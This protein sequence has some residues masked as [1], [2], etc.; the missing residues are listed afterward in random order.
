MS[1]KD[2]EQ[3]GKAQYDNPA[4][5][6]YLARLT[7]LWWKIVGKIIGRDVFPK[8]IELLFRLLQTWIN[9][10]VID[11]RVARAPKS[12][13]AKAD[14]RKVFDERIENLFESG[15][16][17]AERLTTLLRERGF[18]H[19]GELFQRD[20]QWLAQLF[21]YKEP[22]LE[23]LYNYLTAYGLS[24][25][26]DLQ[27]VG[28][29]P[30]YFDEADQELLSTPIH[31]AMDMITA[32]DALEC[33][34]L[35]EWYKAGIY[36]LGDLLIYQDTGG[37][38][39]DAPFRH[40]DKKW[41]QGWYENNLEHGKYERK[42]LH[43]CRLPNPA[44][45]RPTDPPKIWI[46]MQQIR[47]KEK[48]RVKLQSV[49]LVQDTAGACEAFLGMAGLADYMRALNLKSMRD[50]VTSSIAASASENF[51]RLQLPDALEKHG[52]KLGMSDD[53]LPKN[54]EK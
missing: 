7:A 5:E 38:T 41:L 29:V 46:E 23:A 19:I 15:G 10:T 6:K 44:W 26:Y 1:H 13:A 16:E 24:K 33:R 45:V 52:L 17:K 12:E 20:W 51:V 28:W 43:A 37:E 18:V 31:V 30:P 34:V 14:L 47:Q 22:D 4:K 35:P 54:K 11:V 48:E 8:D 53:D 40:A 36:F 2:N 32:R 21:R 3:L 9:D 49:A 42:R 27:Q 25:E 50:L 39:P